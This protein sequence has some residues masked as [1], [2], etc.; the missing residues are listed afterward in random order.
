MRRHLA[1]LGYVLRHKGYV[2]VECLRLGV[3]L[4]I[5]ILH[6]WTKFLPDEW[7]AYVRSF[8]TTDGARQFQPDPAFTKARL[9][10]QK[11]NKHHPQSRVFI[12]DCGGIEPVPMPDVYR[13]ELL[14][15]WRRAAKSTGKPDLLGWYA[16]C[17][18]EMPFHPETRTWIEAQ[19]GYK[20]Q[21]AAAQNE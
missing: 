6:D 21:E 11:R 12:G 7:F 15:D 1:Y 18:H 4:W 17:A 13:R 16:D 5:A 20:P 10:H 2:F 9:L 14:A 19:L 8:Y 3:P